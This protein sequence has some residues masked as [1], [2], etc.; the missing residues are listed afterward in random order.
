MCLGDTGRLERK[1]TGAVHDGAMPGEV[2]RPAS[3]A[4]HDLL[5]SR[6]IEL[7]VEA[8][9]R[10][11]EPFGALLA[12]DGEIVAAARNRVR[13][14][15][16]LTAHAETM[17]IRRLE[18]EDKLGFL[19]AG[20]I[21]ASCEPCPMCVGAMF[22]AGARTVAFALSH[23]RLN[24]IARPEGAPERGFTIGARQIGESA[25]PPMTFR[26]PEREDDAA[27]AHFGFWNG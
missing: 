12:V 20:V 16:D 26:G 10:G 25:R 17:L 18:R 13:T 4:T 21:Y 22:F 19:A 1:P 24:E 14:D 9:D 8:R 23:T 7:S 11:D 2:S 5:L 15:G 6:V 3:G 27:A